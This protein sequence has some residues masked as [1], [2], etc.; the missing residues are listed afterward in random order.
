M[1]FLSFK[2]DYFYGGLPIINTK[3]LSIRQKMISYNVNNS[4]LKEGDFLSGRLKS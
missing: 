2:R 4:S 3:I 1:L